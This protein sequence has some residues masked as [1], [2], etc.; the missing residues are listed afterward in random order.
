MWHAESESLF[1]IDASEL[2]ELYQSI[3]G[4]LCSDVTG[5]NE[6]EANFRR[7]K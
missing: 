4:E 3:D 1:E 5:L 7:K 6:F 2:P